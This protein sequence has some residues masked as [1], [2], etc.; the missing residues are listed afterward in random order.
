MNTFLATCA[1]LFALTLQAQAPAWTDPP[2]LVVGIVVDQMRVDN[3]YRY[4][5]DFGEDGFKRL[6]NEG[7]FQ[8]DAHFEY[9]PTQTGPGHA[10]IYTGTTPAR[11]GIVAND[12][13]DRTT[14]R[15]INCVVDTTMRPVGTEASRGKRSP[16]QLLA[17]T[18]ADE[19]ELR[20][21]RRART[22]GISMKDRAAIL[23]I[24]RTGD[25]AYWFVGGAEGKFITSSWYRDRL[26]AWLEAFNAQELPARYLD[27]TWDLALPR[28]RYH[29]PL[30]DDNRYEEP[31]AQG[32][33]S[34]LPLD[35]QSLH[36]SDPDLGLLLYT[37][38]G[39]T[40]TT[41]MA[42]AAIA[43]DSLGI[44]EVTDLLALSY[45]SIDEI[46]HLMGQRSIE[47][48]DMYVRLDRDLA[49]LLAY[50]DQKVGKDQYT[51]F[52]TGDHGGADVPAY[53][54][55]LKGSAGYLSMLGLRSW[56]D[57]RGF[58]AV[59]DTIRKDQ[60]FLKTGAASGTDVA[61]ARTLM[62]H[63][64]IPCAMSATRL[65]EAGSLTGYAGAMAKGYMP[66]RCGDVTFAMQ[67]DHL[68][69]WSGSTDQG[70][71]HGTAWNYDTQVPVIFFGKGVKRGE[72]LE[73]TSITD[74]VPTVSAI[75]GMA[76]PNAA[77]GRVVAG[78]L[79]QP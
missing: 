53:L 68:R 12:R 32:L 19:L 71:D 15:S 24:G 48:E 44:D 58:A 46:Q 35:L 28:D 18:L 60:I 37:P 20:T 67:P 22:V 8:R 74:I 6:V 56:L 27:R 38:W 78:S 43:G 34:T 57:Q 5:D 29:V 23:P 54:R 49:R 63:P 14:R 36:R 17:S 51:V 76:L 66:Q 7:S 72:V 40:I 4:W 70:S 79:R 11:H 33:P 39:N 73:H 16:S 64:L 55:D 41:D 47:A 3:L 65:Q 45:S 31:I 62:Q 26:P 1:T 21:D 42:I 2:K 59:I 69:E 52:L 9:V 13:Y 25:A 50:L 75:I 10:S 61:I 30:P 77:D